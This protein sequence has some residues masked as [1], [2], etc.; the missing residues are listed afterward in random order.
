MKFNLIVADCPWRFS[1]PL[2]MSDVKRGA[3]ANYRGT[4]DLQKI[5]EL[6]FYTR[7]LA[8]DDS[9]LVLWVPDSMLEDGLRVMRVWGFQQKQILTWVKTGID[10]KRLDS[11][12]I[13]EDVKMAFGMGRIFRCA[14]EHALVGVRGSIQDYLRDRGQRNVFLH[15]NLKHSSK[16]DNVMSAL[17][18][19]IP[20]PF[21]KLEMFARRSRPG[22]IG[23]GNECPATMGEDIKDSLK[24]L[25]EADA[26]NTEAQGKSPG[27]PSEP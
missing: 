7:R 24:K 22:W 12:D 15:P 25:L 17:D 18:K 4:M 10:E 21:P 26:K 19:M 11:E 8:A 16:P 14:D 13:Q 23:C 2:E 20:A 3:D 27:P 9:V 5:V 6:S 1:D